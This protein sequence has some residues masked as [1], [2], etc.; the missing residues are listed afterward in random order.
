MTTDESNDQV[1]DNA[2]KDDNNIAAVQVETIYFD[3]LLV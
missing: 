1:T 2:A 3:F